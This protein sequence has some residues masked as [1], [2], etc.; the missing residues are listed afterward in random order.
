MAT[1]SKNVFISH[2]HEDD[3]GLGKLKELLASKGLDI[4][5]GSIHSEKPNNAKSEDYIK[6]EIL[7]PR[8]EWAST[9]VVYVTPE[10]CGS[11]WVN[12]EIEQAHEMGKRIVGV[13]AHGMKDCEIPLALEEYADAMV[14][15][16]GDSIVDAIV[17]DE[18]VWEKPDG[19]ACEPRPIKRH[20]C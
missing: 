19:E 15:W 14:G 10:T 6:S 16:C 1:Q 8:I 13:W 9:M 3:D 7:R 20:C 4:R 11:D 5:D 2:I 12:W 18:D 17:C